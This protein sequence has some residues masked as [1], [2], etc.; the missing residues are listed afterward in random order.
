M[1]CVLLN[2]FARLV[3]VVAMDV[4]GRPKMPRYEVLSC[5]L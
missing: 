4:E 3:G 1:V 5:E 2:C